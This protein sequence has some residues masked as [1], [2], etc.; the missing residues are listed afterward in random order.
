MLE[1]LAANWI[2]LLVFVVIMVGIAIFLI[3]KK[4]LRQAAIDAIV[5]AQEQMA[6][7]EGKVKMQAAIDY[8]Q[9]LVP[10]LAF[11]PDALLE[12]FIQ[13]VFDQ[14]ESALKLNTVQPT[15][16]EQLEPAVKEEPKVEEVVVEEAKPEEIQ[17]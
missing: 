6:T 7:E 5:Y 11:V 9:Q 17:G 16:P 13:G 12:S 4:G 14:I 2:P 3:K 1:W 8:I 15:Q 10:L